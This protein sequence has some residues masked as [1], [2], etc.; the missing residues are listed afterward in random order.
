MKN[1]LV[2]VREMS[3]NDISEVKRLEIESE[4]SPWS[5]A[6]YRDILEN[7]D[8]ISLVS[9]SD[10]GNTIIGFIIARLI[11]PDILFDKEIFKEQQI[12]IYNITVNKFYRRQGIGRKLL[13]ECTNY[14]L[15]NEKLEIWLE[16]RETNQ[17]AISFYTDLGFAEKYRRK[18]FY[19]NPVED[20]IVMFL[21]K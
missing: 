10:F 2:T 16:V 19:I 8:Y 13:N 21:R 5:E 14:A 18:S 4:L 3:E 7:D 6:D 12:E 17:T 1:N 20:A 9:T 11:T 15:K